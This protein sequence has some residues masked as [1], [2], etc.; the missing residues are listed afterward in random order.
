MFETRLS[1]GDVDRAFAEADAVYADTF[2]IGR[3]TGVPLEPRVII[4]D[5]D[6]W[7][8]RLTVYQSSQTPNVM[9]D[10]LART[11]EDQT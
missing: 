5:F 8:R 2:T 3:H 11:F 7:E 4:A 1:A 10:V 6:P 9:Q